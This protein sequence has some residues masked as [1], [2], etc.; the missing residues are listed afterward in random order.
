MRYTASGLCLKER[1]NEFTHIPW[2]VQIWG[3]YRKEVII[4][5]TQDISQVIT[6]MVFT[7][8]LTT[9]DDP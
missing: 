8:I 2:M 4:I 9:Q 5:Y 1:R 3:Y 7:I 6:C